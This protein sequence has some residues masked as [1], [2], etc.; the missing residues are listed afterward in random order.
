M[1]ILLFN[2]KYNKIKI[3]GGTVT[4]LKHKAESLLPAITKKSIIT[5]F[6]DFLNKELIY[7]AKSRVELI[8]VLNMTNNFLSA[9]TLSNN[10]YYLDRFF[11]SDDRLSIEEGYSDNLIIKEDLLDLVNNYKLNWKSELSNKIRTKTRGNEL[12]KKAIKLFNIKTGEEWEFSSITET[13]KFIQSLNLP[14]NAKVGSISY[15]I[16]NKTIYQGTF[17]FEVLNNK[18]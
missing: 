10:K 4:G 18:N 12:S 17:K 5:Y 11:I 15:S 6:Y 16:K 3:A 7:I 8:K 13:S 9:Y 14:F 1:L 2:P